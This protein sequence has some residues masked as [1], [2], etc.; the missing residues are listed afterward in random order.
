PAMALAPEAAAGRPASPALA[1]PAT[2]AGWAAPAS[3]TATLLFDASDLLDY[4]RH[5]RAP[6]GIQRVQMNL[7]EEALRQAGE[8]AGIVAFAAAEGAWK[9]LP[10]ALFGRLAGLARSGADTGDPA[11]L[12]A[13]QAVAAALR[14]AP[15]LA[16]APGSVLV[17]L[18]TSWWL[19]GYA[20]RIAEAK[21]RH[22]LRY[23]PFL[24]D[25]IPLLVPEH[26]DAN[27][28]GDFARWFAALCLQADAVLV[29]SDCTRDDVRRLHSALAPGRDLPCT[30]VPLDAAAL[31][32][33]ATE[34]AP[35][36]VALRG[37]R[38][39]IL[40]VGTIESRKNHLLV[41]Q[42]WLTL[43]RRH[44][45]AAVPDLVCVGKRGW[46]A[47][48]ALDLHARAPIL[49]AKV[50]LLEAVPDGVLEA[51][52]RGCLFTLANS[53][54]EGWGLP[55]T[56]SLAHGKLVLAPDLPAFRQ[57]GAGGAVFFAPNSEP[58]LV[59]QLWRLATDAGHRQ[60]LEARLAREVRLRGWADIAAQV[61]AAAAACPAGP[62]PLAG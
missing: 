27:L 6:T 23:L 36:P 47:E 55:L 30:V 43:V 59:A 8:H 29:N 52:Y 57:S 61:L 37:G 42:A 28:A 48:P 62:P 44:G 39:F 12:A 51:L 58:D 19:P 54:Y 46:L 26:C 11:W 4:G 22:G 3:A 7:I 50:H 20:R 21:A 24:H 9:P 53:F 17:N 56:E 32:P 49:Q 13:R 40:F 31:S 25:C 34:P 18:G 60:A 41:F 14:D 1:P 35:L 5:S 38:P 33:E 45:A 2:P 16:P 10:A 15:P